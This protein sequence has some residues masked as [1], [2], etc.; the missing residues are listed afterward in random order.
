MEIVLALLLAAVLVVVLY[1]AY[2]IRRAHLMLFEIREYA[3]SEARRHTDAVYRQIEA[4]AWLYRELDP[5]KGLPD[6]RGWAASPDLL[7]ELARHALR[8]RPGNVVECGSGVSTVVLARC[9]QRN[10]GGHV[11]S[12][13]HDAEFAARTRA[14][15]A[16]HGLTEWA[17]VLDAPLRSHRIGDADWQWYSHETLPSGM[18][19]D[20]LVVD[21][22]PM[23]TGPLARYPAGPLLFGR[24]GATGAVFLDDADR[25]EERK[26]V[27]R[28]KREFPG[29]SFETFSTE[30]GCVAIRGIAGRQTGHRSS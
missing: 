17:T 5:A 15:L 11:W 18:A 28:W 20:L 25:R 7:R 13:D 30:R 12:L 19:I 2:K 10:G 21:G 8:E 23:D 16:H 6:A 9:M 26:V 4:L 29:A 1:A 27:E 3:R 14:N 22:P 24:L